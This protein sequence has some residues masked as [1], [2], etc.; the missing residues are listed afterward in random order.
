MSWL[1]EAGFTV[2]SFLISVVIQMIAMFIWDFSVP[3]TT[4]GFGLPRFVL[5][6]FGS[7]V[8]YL[9]HYLQVRWHQWRRS[10]KT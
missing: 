8:F 9:A 6:I 5:W 1:K 7:L 10:K 3:Y 2:R 4:W